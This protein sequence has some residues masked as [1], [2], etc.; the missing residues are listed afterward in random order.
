MLRKKGEGATSRQ[1]K[2]G[3]GECLYC[4]SPGAR[5]WTGP[6]LYDALPRLV[7][8]GLHQTYCSSCMRRTV[9]V[10]SMD[11]LHRLLCETVICKRSMLLPT[12]VRLL[13]TQMEWTTDELNDT[14]HAEFDDFRIRNTASRGAAET[15][16]RVL[17]AYSLSGTDIP[18]LAD[19][20][21]IR[22]WGSL[23]E[24]DSSWLRAEYSPRVGWWAR[25]VK[26]ETEAYAA[27]MLSIQL[28]P[29]TH[30]TTILQSPS[31]LEK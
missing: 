18:R 16:L 2:D 1:M 10:Q 27:L 17:A 24:D 4:R 28:R 21:E 23:P 30:T 20:D 3:S 26:D 13:R 6:Y 12:D 9:S 11:G 7:L 25:Y 14:I 22:K 15:L 19:H 29:G 31:H 8:H 5:H